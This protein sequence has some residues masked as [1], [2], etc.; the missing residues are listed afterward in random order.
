M[1][2]TTNT[3]AKVQPLVYT[4]SK[5]PES[6]ITLWAGKGLEKSPVLSGLLNGK[7]ISL[8]KVEGSK[9]VFF[10]V[11]ING[12]E[13]EQM[14]VIG[15]A[16]VRVNKFGIPKLVIDLKEGDKVVSTVWGDFRKEV[17]DEML[18]SY[19]LDL[20]KRDAKKAEYEAEKAAATA[21]A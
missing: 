20:A 10:N 12:A 9:G 5:N 3:A 15:N 18:V 17:T 11:G 2:T 16:N 13:G 8:F 4:T 19:G 6:Q 21:T 1:T 7:Q 14:K